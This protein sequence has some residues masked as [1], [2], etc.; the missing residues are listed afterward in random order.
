MSPLDSPL[1]VENSEHALLLGPSL[2]PVADQLNGVK[3]DNQ[4]H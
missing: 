3:H 2:L 4:K 1:V